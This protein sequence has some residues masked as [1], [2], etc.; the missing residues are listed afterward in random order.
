MKILLVVEDDPDLVLLVR[1][2]FSLDPEFS[3]DGEASN[4]DQAVAAAAATQPDLIVLDHRLEGPTTGL[5]GAS[6]LKRA[7]PHALIILFSASEE[8]RVS[9]MIDP[10][11]DAFLLKT[12]VRELVSLSRMLLGLG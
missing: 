10:A 5:E 12:D 11:V 4:V 9:A 2:Q 6:L 3:V 7:A 1:L 8:I